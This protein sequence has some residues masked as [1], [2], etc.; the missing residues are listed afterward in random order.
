MSS[1]TKESDKISL[2][3]KSM[4]PLR[5][6]YQIL[7]TVEPKWRWNE[8]TSMHTIKISDFAR[9]NEYNMKV[10]NENE[11]YYGEE[12]NTEKDWWWFKQHDLDTSKLAKQSAL[13]CMNNFQCSF[14]VRKVDK[15]LGN[16]NGTNIKSC[17]L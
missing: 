17:F 10:Y 3:K 6:C 8:V 12:V 11:G 5:K 7:P 16:R 15:N 4:E 9:N 14:I 1:C 13:K 2:L